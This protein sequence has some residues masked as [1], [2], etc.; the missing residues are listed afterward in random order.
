MRIVD[1]YN[2]PAQ[3]VPDD[4]VSAKLYTVK[5][6]SVFSSK[7]KYFHVVDGLLS[8]IIHDILGGVLPLH[9]KAILNKV[10]FQDKR[11]TIK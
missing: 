6:N 8:D 5:G 7:S 10:V 11:F 3:L 9:V 2:R 1:G 4:P